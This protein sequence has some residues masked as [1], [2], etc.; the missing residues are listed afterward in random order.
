MLNVKDILG[1]LQGAFSL[2]FYFLC[3]AEPFNL[4]QSHLFIFAFVA[5]ALGYRP[6]KII[7]TIY[8]KEHSFMF[9]SRR[10]MVSSLTFRYLI[11]FQFIFCLWGEKMF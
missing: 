11:H 6:K 3:L 4:T 2:S 5:F 8:D 1:M 9:S 7:A 10:F